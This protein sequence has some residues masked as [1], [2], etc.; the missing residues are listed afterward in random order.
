MVAGETFM[1]MATPKSGSVGNEL[2]T[3]V[4]WN[5]WNW[6]GNWDLTGTGIYIGIGNWDIII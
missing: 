5:W 3:H 2:G 1:S 4:E 6:E